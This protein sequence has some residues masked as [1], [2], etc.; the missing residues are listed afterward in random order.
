MALVNALKSF[1][2]F[3]TAPEIFIT[4]AAILF[5]LSLRYRAFWKPK[6]AIAL[7]ILATAFLAVSMLDENFALI[8][9]K[10]D[11]VPIVA[12][13]FLVGFFVWLSMH[14]A[15]ANDERLDQGLQPR[16]GS[17][18]EEQKTWVWPDLVY[19]ELLCMV[20]GMIVLVVWSI[21]LHAPIEEPA[22]PARTP[23]PSKAPWYFLGL[24][25]MLVY[26]D[27]WLAG[28]VF[29]SLIILGLMAIPYIDVNP[30]G[31]GY[32]TF[33]QRKTEITIFMFGF[34]IQW[35]LLVILGTF[36]RGPNWN[37]FGP[38]EEWDLHKLMALNNVNLSEYF[39]IKLLGSGLPNTMLLRELPGILLVLAYVVV[40]P[41]ILARGMLKRFYEKMGPYRYAV[42]VMLLLMQIALPIKMVLRWVANLKY[43]VAMP[44]IFFNI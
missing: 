19:T 25:E 26:Y 8:V 10:P 40:L 34:L 41:G 33:K 20:I 36:L 7:G 43:I 5:F 17:D 2:N 32:F 44:E 39:W 37:F 11:N 22:N 6:V 31:N 18:G 24:Q 9:K 42:F 15:H 35:V 16:E 13:L 28:V 29:P 23:N 38:Y 30:K 4:A 12:M 27:P 14:Q 21:A 3:L 1:I